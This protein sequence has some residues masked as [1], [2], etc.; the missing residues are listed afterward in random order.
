MPSL[1]EMRRA[2]YQV[3]EQTST[4]DTLLGF[5]NGVDE[6]MMKRQEK[7]RKDKSDQVKFYLD[8]RQSGYSE[9]AAHE[10]VNRLYRS[11]GFIEDLVKKSSGENDTFDR[12]TQ[13]RESLANAKTRADIGNTKA[14]TRQKMARA[15]A[16]STG[17]TSASGGRLN[18]AWTPNQIQSYIGFLTNEDRNPDYGT[19]ENDDEITFARQRL[20]ESAGFSQAAGEPAAAAPAKTVERVPMVKPDGTK[21]MVAKTDVARARAKGYKPANG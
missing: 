12:P 15:K 4:I 6:Q 13:D 19:P 2:G 3:P 5:M 14:D 20:R 10:K 17:K 21:V 11:T 18:D 9:D 16:Y 8:L 7:E 1:D